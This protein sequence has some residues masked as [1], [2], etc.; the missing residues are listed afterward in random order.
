LLLPLS[1]ERFRAVRYLVPRPQDPFPFHQQRAP[2]KALL[3]PLSK[4]RFRAVRYLVTI[5]VAPAGRRDNIVR[6]VR[7]LRDRSGTEMQVLLG[8]LHWKPP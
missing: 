2:F 6:D 8:H 1:K 4:E 5:H 7:N 3:L